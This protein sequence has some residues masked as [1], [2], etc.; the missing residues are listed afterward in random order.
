MSWLLLRRHFFIGTDLY[1]YSSPPIFTGQ[2][3]FLRRDREAAG[4]AVDLAPGR[5]QRLLGGMRDERVLG[6]DP[7][8]VL[9]QPAHR[10]LPR[11]GAPGDDAEPAAAPDRDV[12]L[13]HHGRGDP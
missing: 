5:D 3:H 8:V 11:R 2:V 7:L 10:T 12:P 6:V 1:R 4:S 13:E 9:E